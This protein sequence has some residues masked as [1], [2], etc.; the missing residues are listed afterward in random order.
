M[1]IHFNSNNYKKSYRHKDVFIHKFD[2]I[3]F[4]SC[5]KISHNRY[6]LT[7]L[8]D[9]LFCLNETKTLVPIKVIIPYEDYIRISKIKFGV[10]IRFNN[11]YFKQN[12]LYIYRNNNNNRII[13]KST[14]H[15]NYLNYGNSNQYNHE[16]IFK[17]VLAD[18]ALLEYMR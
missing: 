8:L 18:R 1:V 6:E 10:W 15:D 5:V 17:A 9:Y 11:N 3:M 4:L 16:L 2:R 7:Y 12:Y 14:R 13:F